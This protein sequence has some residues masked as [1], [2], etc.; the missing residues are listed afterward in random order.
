MTRVVEIK[1]RVLLNTQEEGDELLRGLAELE[2]EN[3][4]PTG[5]AIESNWIELGN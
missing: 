2:E 5:A 4:F 1:R 3:R